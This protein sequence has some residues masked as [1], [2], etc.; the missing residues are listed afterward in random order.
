MDNYPDNLAPEFCDGGGVNTPFEEWWPRVQ[1]SFPNVPECVAR[2]WL[3]EHWGYSPYSWLPSKLYKFT[4]ERW[5]PDKLVDIRSRHSNFIEDLTE[6]R[7]HGEHLLRRLR[8]QTALFMEEYKKFPAPIIVLDNL[9]GHLENDGIAMSQYKSIPSQYILIEG[10][11][12]FNISL[13]LQHIN[14]LSEPID[15]WIMTKLH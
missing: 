11:R 7:Q 10:H 15:I 4:L 9:D 6:C 13:Y 1:E 5:S 14:Q 12:R 2:Q 3:H 8:Y